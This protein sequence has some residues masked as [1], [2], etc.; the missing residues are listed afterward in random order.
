MTLD[1]RP[2]ARVELANARDLLAALPDGK[3]YA[4]YLTDLLNNPAPDRWT[5][6]NVV[7]QVDTKVDVM[8]DDAEQ[9]RF[10]KME[11]RPRRP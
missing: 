1:S 10:D 9:S 7:R 6:R 3:D 8:R 5:L 11:E 2:E 4:R